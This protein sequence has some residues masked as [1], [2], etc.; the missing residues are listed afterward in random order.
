[1]KKFMALLIVAAMITILFTGCSTKTE[2]SKTTAETNNQKAVT[3][4]VKTEKLRVGIVQAVNHPSLDE[5]RESAIKSL[6]SSSIGKDIEII[7]KDAQGDPTNVNTIIS[8]FVG[9]E[10][11]LIIPIATGA[12]QS[13]AAATK[14]IPIVFAAVSYPV[15]AGLVVDMNITDKNITGVSNAIAIED[16]FKL[17]QK[18]TPEVKT[19]G[20]IYNTSEVNAVASTE[21]AKAYCDE[22]G[23]KYVEATI[24]N[25]GDLLQASQSLVG[26]VDAIFVPN[27]NTIASAMSVLSAEAIKAGIPVYTGADSMVVDGGFATVGIDYKVLGKQT[28]DM[29]ARI[30]EGQSISDNHVEVINQYS[31]IINMTTAKAL[32]IELDKEIIKDFKI[33]E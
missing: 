8:Q 14:D 32:G 23:L 21:R 30:L 27:D 24:T 16:I 12:A 22:N 28:G 20:I 10:V 11:D 25:S 4:T 7:Y 19:Y 13:A 31:N 2:N 6:E 33:I 18:L 17:S 1:M 3:E 26:K 15:K 5:I 9:E 29:A